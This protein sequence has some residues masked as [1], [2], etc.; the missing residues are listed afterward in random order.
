MYVHSSPTA[1][2]IR[3]RPAAR[4]RMVRPRPRALVGCRILYA[5]SSVAVG[6][7]IPTL[8]NLGQCSNET[9]TDGNNTLSL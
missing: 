8:I 3:H 6:N 1:Y 2:H 7:E 5:P 4:V 9:Q